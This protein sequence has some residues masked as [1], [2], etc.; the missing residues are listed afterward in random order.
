MVSSSLPYYLAIYN[1]SVIEGGQS[2]T[3]INLRT[4]N[5]TNTDNRLN[6]YLGFK[7]SLIM[8]N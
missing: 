6:K 4:I 8:L 7:A 3:G 2:F 5:Y 1:I